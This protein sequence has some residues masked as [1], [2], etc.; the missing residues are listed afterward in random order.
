V[1]KSLSQGAETGCKNIS[2]YFALAVLAFD[3][4]GL[5]AFSSSSAKGWAL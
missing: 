2:S 5:P 4:A 1:K 3:F